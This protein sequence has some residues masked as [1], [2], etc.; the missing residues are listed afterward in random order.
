MLAQLSK[1]WYNGLIVRLSGTRCGSVAL[2]GLGLRYFQK[3]G[4]RASHRCMDD[5]VAL[6][7]FENGSAV[8]L[9]GLLGLSEPSFLDLLTCELVQV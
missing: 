7:S 6:C 5:E 2:P 9:T 8:S 4:S 3:L 1:L